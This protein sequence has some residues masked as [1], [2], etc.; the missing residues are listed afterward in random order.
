MDAHHPSQPPSAATIEA[1]QEALARGAWEEARSA[2]EC[3]LQT[4]DRDVANHS[5]RV[6]LDPEESAEILSG[7]AE[8]LWWLGEIRKSLDYWEQAYSGFR[9]RP[10]PAQ[11]AFVAIQLGILYDANLGN[12][13]AAA[14]WVARAARLVEEHEL[15]PLR[16]WVLIAEASAAADP[17]QH[18]ALA[19]QAHQL[20][21]ISGDRDLE[22]CALTEIGVALIDQ[23]RITEGM[24]FHDEAMAGAL[25][26]EGQLDTVVF[27]A[28]QMMTS[29]SRCAQYE[30]MTQWIRAADR[31]VERYGCPYLSAT[32]RTHYGEV[33]FATGDWTRA[34]E[35]LHAALCLSE[36]SLPAVRA[37]ALARLAELRLAQGSVEEAE[38]LMMGFEDQE[39]SAPVF[40]RIHLVRGKF[41]LAASTA[42]RWLGVTGEDRLESTLLLELLGE[43]EISQ[44]QVEAAAERGRTLAELGRSLDCQVMLARGERL[45][46][47]A[48]VAASDSVAKQHLEVALR[49]FTQL[50]MSF[51]AARTRLLLA[52]ALRELD[53]EVAEAE[54]RAALAIFRR[55]GA[56]TDAKATT[57][58]LREI[59]TRTRKRIG[60]T[61]DLAGLTQREVE[62][63]RL[64]AQG[65]SD[66]EIATKLVLS[67]HTIHRHIHSIL[68]KLDLPSRAAAAAYAARHDLL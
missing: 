51:E 60:K 3:A 19:R 29:Y 11:A 14:G 25:A 40:T 46:G 59:E 36:Y 62:V 16:G 22:L 33:L 56:V 31:F 32:C 64:V 68:T 39:A 45:Q 21:R 48:L 55:L 42:R 67:R 6:V 58:V 26:G 1:G 15:E 52:Q 38:R 27:A 2:F 47:Q 50:E 61:P 24:A 35:E 4:G 57:S 20:G 37:K 13:A 10:D 17:D 44:S 23:G 8:A 9:Q 18:E 34:E 30:R 43:A 41:A 7:L 54:A 66:K 28:C 12:R 49:E 53:P 5:L 65:L 63:L